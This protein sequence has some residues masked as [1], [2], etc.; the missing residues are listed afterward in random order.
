[1]NTGN[2][3]NENTIPVAGDDYLW[4]RSG[5]PDPEIKKLEEALGKFQYNR[6]APIFPAVASSNRWAFVRRIRPFPVFA[7]SI[8]AI[9]VI[10]FVSF[11]VHGRKPLPVEV[12]GWDVSQTA[13]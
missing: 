9:A 7:T 8:G 12:A 13:G 1:M 10:A 11:V 5:A 6:P 2:D 3:P 4:D